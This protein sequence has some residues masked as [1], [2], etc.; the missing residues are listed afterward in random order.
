[1]CAFITI[2]D[3]LEIY[4]EF[5]RIKSLQPTKEEIQSRKAKKT[6]VSCSLKEKS[7]K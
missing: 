5:Q 4:E 7:S 1:M 6:S 2:H 3:R